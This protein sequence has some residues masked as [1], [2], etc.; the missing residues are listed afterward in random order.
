MQIVVNLSFL[1]F[2]YLAFVEVNCEIFSAVTELEKLAANE[3]IIFD[4]LEILATQINHEYI[5]K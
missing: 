4:E 3:R 2:I 5:D 1:L